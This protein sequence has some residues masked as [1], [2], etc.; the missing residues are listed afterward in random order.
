MRYH[1]EIFDQLQYLFDVTGFNDHQLH[2][3]IYFQNHINTEVMEKA[4]KLLVKTVPILSR[5]YQNY[6]GTSYW[7]DSKNEPNELFTIVHTKED[8]NKF[9]LGKTNAE[10]GPQIKVCLL[11]AAQDSISIIINHMV[12]DG[13]GG[14]QCLYYLA[15]LYSKLIVD[16]TY[17]PDHMIDGNRSFEKIIDKLT[18]KEK[19]KLLFFHIKENNQPN[20]LTFPMS[21]ESDI[22]PF[23]I[24]HEISKERFGKLREY[25]KHN[26]ATINDILLTAY[27]RALA[28]MLDI[29]GENISIPI[30]IDMRRYLTDQT[31]DSLTNFSSTAITSAIVVKDESFSQTLNKVSLELNRLKND[32][33]GLNSFIKLHTLYKIV[34]K[35]LSYKILAKVL[36]NPAI[37]MT[38][39]GI[40]DS[41]LLK[42]YGSPIDNA[43]EFGSIKYRPHFQVA[44]SS[45]EDR[46][47]LSVNLY[48]SRQDQDNMYR[49]LKI[50][51]HELSIGIS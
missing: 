14:K 45:F 28:E 26:Q 20:N 40:L 23:L 44:V 47:T 27:F 8:F 7:E 29:Y 39:I 33:L 19:L 21:N 32:S 22:S 46:L 5:V 4:V 25:G 38:N 2:C 49:F 10:T 24:T 30:M 50:L 42:F 36:K 34:G 18:L 9:T 17:K 1:A 43:F 12:T 6:G 41:N 15:D 16:P 51:D 37:C 3:I 48:G 35:K 11:K 13:A 31:K